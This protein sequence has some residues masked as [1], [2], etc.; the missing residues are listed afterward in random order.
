MKKFFLYLIILISF[1]LYSQKGD[2][3]KVQ[4]F[5]FD[6]TVD[7]KERK[8]LREGIAQFTSDLKTSNHKAIL[9]RSRAWLYIRLKEYTAAISDLSKVIELEPDEAESYFLRGLCK[10]YSQKT[11]IQ[12]SCD[13]FK[14]AK[15]LNF[16]K[17]DW[18]SFGKECVNQ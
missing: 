4:T 1:N 11:Y 7:E 16:Q 8:K 2:E 3:K 15:E 17:V 18:N 10:K 14:K 12:T 13:D 6:T 5:A 9:Y